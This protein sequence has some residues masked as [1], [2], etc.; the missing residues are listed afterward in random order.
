MEMVFI[1]IAKFLFVKLEDQFIRIQVL[2]DGKV[3][4]LMRLN[5]YLRSKSFNTSYNLHITFILLNTQQGVDK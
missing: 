3:F 1:K 4:Q 5:K 2:S